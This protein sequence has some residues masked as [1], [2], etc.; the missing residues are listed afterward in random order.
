MVKI[1]NPGWPL[2]RIGPMPAQGE[3]GHR[4]S[5]KWLKQ[6]QF[7]KGSTD[8]FLECFVTLVRSFAV[9]CRQSRVTAT[10][11][12]I[13]KS[14][15]TNVLFGVHFCQ[16]LEPG[17]C[18][19]ITASSIGTLF[20]PDN[21]VFGMNGTGPSEKRLIPGEEFWFQHS[22]FSQAQTHGCLPSRDYL[23]S[24]KFIPI[25]STDKDILS[26]GSLWNA[27]H[28]LLAW[29]ASSKTSSS[30]SPNYLIRK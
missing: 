9:P 17:T 29:P 1:C 5:R 28:C 12:N 11:T 4:F 13:S 24:T 22:C 27:S 26:H 20:K 25:A 15:V 3:R 18:D 21:F 16:D 30:W 2:A 23:V 7:L 8:F 14:L 6:N 19:V 10:G